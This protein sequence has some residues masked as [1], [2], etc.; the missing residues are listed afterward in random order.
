MK[1]RAKKDDKFRS[2]EVGALIEDLRGQFKVFGEG[3]NDLREKVDTVTGMVGQ[4]AEKSTMSRM[5]IMVLKNTVTQ[6]NGKLAGIEKDMRL[7]RDNLK[8]KVDR[9]EFELLEKKVASI[10]G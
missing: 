7:I 4:E 1:K 6:I 5:D 2:T 9:R 10:T 3:L 8:S